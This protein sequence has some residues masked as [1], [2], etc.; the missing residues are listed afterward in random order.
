MKK[1]KKINKNCKIKFKMK[2]H[3]LKTLLKI[4]ISILNHLIHRYQ[5]ILKLKKVYHFSNLRI[6]Y[7]CNNQ[8]NLIINQIFLHQKTII[9]QFFI[10][11]VINLIQ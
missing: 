1:F 4:K 11:K 8:L 10:N 6:N 2:S 7:L 5:V 3:N 9:N